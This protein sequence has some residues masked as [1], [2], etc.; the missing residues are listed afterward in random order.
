VN[1][2]RLLTMPWPGASSKRWSVGALIPVVV[3]LSAIVG[4]ASAYG[5]PLWVGWMRA[6]TYGLVFMN[7]AMWA[8][9]LP[10][11]LLMA[12]VARRLQ[13]PGVQ[14]D[15]CLSLG[16]YALLSI[17][18]PT[19]LI[20]GI[21]G[22]VPVLAVEMVLGAGLGMTFAVLPSYC[23]S[24]L[25][26][27]ALLHGVVWRWL[28]LPND[29]QPGFLRLTGPLAVALWLAIALL[30]RRALSPQA[31]LDGLHAPMFFLIRLGKWQRLLG[32]GNAA[33]DT[34]LAGQIP[35]W[36]RTTVD[37]RASGPGHVVQSLRVA[38]GET[39][40]PQ[41]RSRRVRKTVIVLLSCVLGVGLLVLQAIGYAEH[42]DGMPVAIGVR[43]LL[44]WCVPF[45]SAVL[46]V[47]T[48]NVL[49]QRWSRSNAE[50]PL[51]ALLPGLGDP[52]QIKRALLRASLPPTLY[53]Q[54]FLLVVSLLV[55]AWWH[56]GIESGLLLLLGQLCGAALL[57]V[58]TLMVFAGGSLSGSNHAGLVVLGMVW[59]WLPLVSALVS[60]VP[61]PA[62]G[63]VVAIG[64]VAAA[65]VLLWLGRRGWRGLQQRAHP[66]LAN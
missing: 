31:T 58:L 53:K 46:A 21:V 48:A 14:R 45:V 34:R 17:G 3:L 5:S 35:G 60:R 2:A 10:D 28:A 23:T 29:M 13:V 40:M 54:T 26:F 24:V 39:F 62:L 15:A 16:F 38:L 57:L 8:M 61:L 43:F 1:L 12:C 52:A 51:L 9:L 19:A 32:V 41:T 30:W 56:L 25:I 64:W 6:A 22:N 47:V 42:G 49:R 11:A 4:A 55:A 65:G 33:T 59:F 20:G 66:F 50:L 36:L 18:V 27:V 44:M 7:A 63:L 37:L